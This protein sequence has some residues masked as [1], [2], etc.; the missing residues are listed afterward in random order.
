[1]KN[2]KKIQFHLK[3]AVD[4]IGELR[5]SVGDGV[6]PSE[7]EHRVLLHP[8]APPRLASSPAVSILEKSVDAAPQAAPEALVRGG[9]EQGGSGE[10]RRRAHEARALL[11]SIDMHQFIKISHKARRGTISVE[12]PRRKGEMENYVDVGRRR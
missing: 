7:Q 1:M 6:E 9:A 4:V 2:G 11:Q 5:Q 3:G 10:R 12:K 8:L